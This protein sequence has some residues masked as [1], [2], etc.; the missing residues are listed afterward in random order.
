MVT[1]AQSDGRA[2]ELDGVLFDN[3][4]TLVDTRELLLLSFRH[5][6]RE[7]LGTQLADDE[8]LASVGTPLADQMLGLAE[9]DQA[10]AD[11]LI[12]VYRTFNHRVHDEM[13]GLFPGIKELLELLAQHDVKM[14]VVTS[15]KHALCEHG[16]SIL[17]VN[18]YFDVLIGADDWP[19]H[20]PQPGPVSR[21]CELL[22]VEP[23]R[24][25]YVGDSPFDLQA[26]NGAGTVTVAAL[27]GMFS[28]D[29]LAPFSPTFTCAAPTDLIELVRR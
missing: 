16:L 8:Y 5:A 18:S 13:V 27:W 7:V 23:V 25:A 4:G 14:G 2:Y 26:G 11:Q 21:G 12:E 1:I 17:G 10:V 15:K 22:G 9:G 24:C 29:A 28:P 20:K 3:D 6:T 19:E